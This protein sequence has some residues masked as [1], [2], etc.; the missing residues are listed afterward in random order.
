MLA[1]L[2]LNMLLA[3]AMSK[4]IRIGGLFDNSRFERDEVAFLVAI[5]EINADPTILANH[6]LIPTI[7]E[8][9]IGDAG[10]VMRQA[11][12]LAEDGVSIVVGTPTSSS[13]IAAS[14]ALSGTKIPMISNAA[15]SPMLS[16]KGLYPDFIRVVPPDSQQSQVLTDLMERFGWTRFAVITSDDDYGVGGVQSL[17]DQAYVRDWSVLSVQRVPAAVT[18]DTYQQA[19]KAVRAIKDAGAR[20]IVLNCLGFTAAGILKAAEQVGLL[21]LGHQY[22]VTDGITANEHMLLDG[23]IEARARAIGML[24]SR[25]DARPSPRIL[26]FLERWENLDKAQYPTA[27][28]PEQVNVFSI[29]NYDAAWTAA[30]AL[31]AAIL[32]HGEN[33]IQPIT[34]PVCGS[35]NTPELPNHAILK[36]KILG[37][38]YDTALTGRIAFDELGDRLHQHYEIVNFPRAVD[39]FTT[40][41]DWS[42]SDGVSVDLALVSWAGGVASPPD[43]RVSLEG[44][45]LKIS[46]IIEPPFVVRSSNGGISGY[47]VDIMNQLASTEGFTYELIESDDPVYGAEISPGIFNGLIGQVQFREVDAII[48]AITVTAA[49]VRAVTF[50]PSFMGVSTS[51][52]TVKPDVQQPNAWSFLE[53]FDDEIWWAILFMLVAFSLSI[54]IFESY[55]P[56]ASST[57]SEKWSNFGLL[58][59][60]FTTLLYFAGNGAGALPSSHAGRL[61]HASFGVVALI[62]MAIYE[63][64][65]TASLAKQSLSKTLDTLAD[66]TT[67]GITLTTVDGSAPLAYLANTPS[68]RGLIPKLNNLVNRSQTGYAQVNSGEIDAFIFDRPLLEYAAGNDA[69]CS[70]RVASEEFQEASYA[71]ALQEGSIYSTKFAQAMLRL[72]E[73]GT[74]EALSSRWLGL[75]PCVEEA[76]ADVSEIP[77]TVTINYVAGLF[78]IIA[79]TIIAVTIYAILYTYLCKLEAKHVTKTG[80]TPS[81]RGVERHKSKHFILGSNGELTE[82]HHPRRFNTMELFEESLDR[83]ESHV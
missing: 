52:L 83:T 70:L 46:T 54:W 43:G 39:S 36:E 68:L 82:N 47:C 80:Y 11:C 29:L 65:L 67:D 77:Q 75:G 41:G 64:N 1:L 73:D 35:L 45:H 81:G 17:I 63:G 59:A 69:S 8:I 25:P 74:L 2:V 9:D 62:L 58:Y 10:G 6:T 23:T 27:G 60:P 66:L 44:A 12:R 33:I 78:Y 34:E 57:R 22:I 7:R 51:F 38:D 14:H 42:L 16:N 50:M 79:G 31:D 24:G 37:L 19:L 55:S 4:D 26:A 40:V 76:G 71:F 56:S 30:L 28:E 21:G 3:H 18:V 48:G 61:L 72:Q 20:F 32:E 13:S 53:V 5:E 15:T 49:R